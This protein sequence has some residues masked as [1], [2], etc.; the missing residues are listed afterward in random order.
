MT[1]TRDL[2]IGLDFGS[3]SVRGVLLDAHGKV[4]A[5][6]S[7]GYPRWNDGKWRDDSRMMY[8][9][10]PLDYFE[11]M[12]E[13]IRDI[14]AETDRTRIAAIALDTTGSTPSALRSDGAALALD[15]GFAE[16]ADAMFVLWKDHTA[17]DEAALVNR[18]A[19]ESGTK[20]LDYCGGT[21]SEEWFFSKI[22]HIIRHAPRVAAATATYAECGDY[23]AGALA[24]NTSPRSMVRNRCAASHKAMWN[25]KWGGLPDREF[26]ERIDPRLGELRDKLYTDT[27]YAGTCIGTLSPAWAE[28]LGLDTLVAIGVGAMDG[29]S[30]AVGAGIKPGILL[31]SVG[32]SGNDFLVVHECDRAIPGI[33]GQA[34]GSIIPGMVAFEAGQA[35]VGDVFA[36]FRHLLEY[37]GKSVDL[38]RL[39]ADAAAL[40]QEKEELS[41]LDFFSGR[42]TPFCNPLMQGA[43]TGLTLGSSAPAV[44]LAL[45]RSVVMGSRSI[46]E[47]YLSCG[48]A[49]NEIRVIG[50]VA[51]KSPLL[52]QILADALQKEI[53]L[54][55]EEQCCALG[56][57][58]FAAV[59]GGLYPDLRS[60]QEAMAPGIRCVTRP[61]P[62]KKALYDRLYRRYKELEKFS[63]NFGRQRE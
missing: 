10:H 24:G 54:V 15:P 12:T 26:L 62:K 46:Y 17:I 34:E 47:H 45:Q 60:A 29:H 13:V 39:E 37:S 18:S 8:R 52:R 11:S 50:G 22:L 4:V 53:L 56:S 1:K 20:Y 49:V 35:A 7:C 32:T 40:D 33:C 58:M 36:W 63:E 14:A 5:A 2:V 43:L 51:A 19:A 31:K 41:A 59:A 6:S 55:D 16:D 38:R 27:A 21:Y 48:L 30:G 57:G 44:Y 23:L 25:A 9:Q 3:D 28:K 42:R 61:D